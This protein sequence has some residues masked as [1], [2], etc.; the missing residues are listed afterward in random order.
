MKKL[1]ALLAATALTTSMASGALAGSAT[2]PVE[3]PEPIAVP[4]AGSGLGAGGAVVAGLA[5]IALVAAIA[6]S[7]DDDAAATTTTSP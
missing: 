6:A 7:D 2:P 4:V 3:E 1:T 5:A